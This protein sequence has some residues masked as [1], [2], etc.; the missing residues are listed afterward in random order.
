MAHDD[1][2]IT[3]QQF[4]QIINKNIKLNRFEKK[5][6]QYEILIR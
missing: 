5:D 1:L 2:L 4:G 3:K 6:A